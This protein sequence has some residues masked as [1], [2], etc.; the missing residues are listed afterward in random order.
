MSEL[1]LRQIP[2][3]LNK[4]IQRLC[5]LKGLLQ[6]FSQ[7]SPDWGMAPSLSFVLA[8]VIASRGDRRVLLSDFAGRRTLRAT[9]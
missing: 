2:D 5:L 6:G 8:I 9:L 3:H 7:F 1:I 4:I